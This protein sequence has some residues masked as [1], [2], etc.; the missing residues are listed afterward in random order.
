MKANKKVRPI[1]SFNNVTS[2]NYL[3]CHPL[4]PCI[5]DKCQTQPLAYTAESPVLKY[6]VISFVK[7]KKLIL[8]E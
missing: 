4:P 8:N 1:F 7:K 6:I 5:R 3:K 2:I